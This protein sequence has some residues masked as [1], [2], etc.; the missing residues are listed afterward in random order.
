MFFT[1]VQRPRMNHKNGSIRI[2]EIAHLNKA[3]SS[4]ATHYVQ[5]VVA[6]ILRKRRLRVP[7]DHLRFLGF[8]AVLGDVVAVP[9]DPAELPGRAPV[10]A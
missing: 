7:H 4:S 10:A 1:I 5:L 3:S 2:K 6:R 9:I 8:N